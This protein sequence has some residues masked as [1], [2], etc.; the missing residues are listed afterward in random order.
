MKRLSMVLAMG[1]MAAMMAIPSIAADK[2]H[3]MTGFISDSKCGAMHMGSGGDCVKKCIAG[4]EKPVFVDSKKNVWAI[5]NP[6][7]VPADMDGKSVKVTMTMDKTNKSIHVD[8][9]AAAS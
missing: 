6:D 2:T 8:K 5:D 1:G 3:T 9:V 4:G 7:A